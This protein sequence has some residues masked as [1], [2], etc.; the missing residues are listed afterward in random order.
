[1]ANG[2]LSNLGIPKRRVF[3]SYHHGNDRAYY[4][5]FSQFFSA[6][7]D[8]I[9][10]NSVDRNI[11]STN[12]DYIIRNIR[13]NYIS[14]TSCTIVL[15]GSQTP[16]R[17][18]VDW[19]IKASLDKNHGLIGINLP[20]NPS[21]Q[22]KYIVPDRLHDNI[23]SGYALWIQWADLNVG[24]HYLVSKIEEANAKSSYLIDNSR[25]L[26]SRNG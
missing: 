9:Q 1:M 10:D 8:V 5:S 18:F 20:S 24:S 2:L 26:R 7:Y 17:K 23:V 12:T 22:G 11:D 3:V 15:C 14:G 25:A 16:W 21:Q 4:D 6:S 19:E 13:E